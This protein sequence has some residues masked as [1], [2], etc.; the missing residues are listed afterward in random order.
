[1]IV[2]RILDPVIVV[3]A[4]FLLAQ[5]YNIVFE[6]H[7][8]ILA[9]TSF[10]LVLPIFKGVGLYKP[11]RSLSPATLGT[12]ALDRMDCV[13]WSTAFFRICHSNIC[14]F[15]SFLTLKLVDLRPCCFADT[16]LNGLADSSQN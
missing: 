13:T 16:A 3:L 14:S 7:L 6:T 5:F 12:K 11:Y 9:V 1:M 10:L 4:L 2:Q 8:T 15:F